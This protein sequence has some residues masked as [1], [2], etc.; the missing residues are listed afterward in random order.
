MAVCKR[1][2]RWWS[3]RVANSWS[4][5]SLFFTTLDIAS[6]L[7]SGSTCNLCFNIV[8]LVGKMRKRRRENIK[9]EE[10]E[11][12]STNNGPEFHDLPN[13]YKFET[14]ELLSVCILLLRSWHVHFATKRLVE[15]IICKD[16]WF[17][18]MAMLVSIHFTQF[19]WRAESRA[20]SN[21]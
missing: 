6:K 17:P 2:W 20:G 14:F 1:N 18:N 13:L 10:E 16:T 21:S 15:N 9:N 11:E 5:Q 7:T 12:E 3:G 8:W 19:Q 4:R